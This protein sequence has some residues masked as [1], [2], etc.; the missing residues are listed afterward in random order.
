M[1][2]A[3]ER[4]ELRELAASLAHTVGGPVIFGD[5]L[6]AAVLR[7][8]PQPPPADGAADFRCT[9]C[10][11]DD[12]QASYPAWCDVNAD[13]DVVELDGEAQAEEAWCNACETPATLAARPG[14]GFAD[15]TGSAGRGELDPWGAS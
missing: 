13:F 7:Y 12:V 10:G 2:T 8:V 1:L 3:A 9:H 5:R 11:S 6:A 14:S 15:V 4:R